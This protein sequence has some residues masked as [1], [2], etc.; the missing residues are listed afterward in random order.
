[1]KKNQTFN[2]KDFG[3]KL[4]K[5]DQMRGAEQLPTRPGLEIDMETKPIFE[6]DFPGAKRLVD[7]VAIITGGDSGIGRAVA[8]GYVKEGAKVVL[9]YREETEDAKKTV[10]RI[11]EL[12]GE[13]LAIDGDVG[14]PGFCQD[15]VQKTLAAFGGIHILINNAGEQHPEKDILNI[16]PEQLE[17][18]FK[19]NIFAMFYMVQAALPHLDAY[20]SIINTSSVTA[21]EG[22]G[23]LMDYAATK[24]A[25]VSFTRSLAQNLA[26]KKIRVNQIA[27][28]PIWTPLIPSTFDGEKVENFGEKTLFDRAGQPIELVEAYIY[29]GWLRASGYMTGQ[30][31]HINGG[32]FMTV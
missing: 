7:K 31:I 9:V 20:A 22:S 5:A 18:T 10:N 25:V 28:G 21:Y 16:T 17:R 13:V 32:Q 1:M 3:Q 12:G 4:E 8:I 14:D 2:E 6:D 29:F 23:G 15:V 24:G 27:P 30:T 19:T 26:S 11:Q